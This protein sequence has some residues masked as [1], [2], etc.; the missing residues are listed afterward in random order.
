MASSKIAN[1][2]VAGWTRRPT[3]SPATPPRTPAEIAPMTAHP[4][5]GGDAPRGRL[6]IVVTVSRCRRVGPLH[7]ATNQGLLHHRAGTLSAMSAEDDET[8]ADA[9]TPASAEREDREHSTVSVRVAPSFGA[10]MVGRV[11]IGVGNTTRRCSFCDRREQVVATLVHARGTYICDGCV[12]LAAAAIDDPANDGQT[13]R[14]RP[15]PLLTVDRDRAEAEIERVFETV[16]GGD[17]PD[18]ERSRAIESGDNLLEVMRQVHERV[19]VRNQ[20][21]VSIDS[22]RF[23]DD[24]EAEV[25]FVLML[26]GP[27]QNPGMHMPSKGYAV[28]ENGT[29]KMSRETYAELV[30]RLGISIPPVVRL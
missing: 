6:L 21:D 4:R 22:V 1:H 2:A 10:H 16:L 27:R 3:T 11:G 18:S 14:I 30:G 17:A 15:R 26:P 7:D 13:V 24:T 29:W 9:E 8:A 19:P 5:G 12:R 23:L 20:V 28:V 25:N